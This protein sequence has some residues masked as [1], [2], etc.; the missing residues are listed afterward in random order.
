MG[1]SAMG[2]AP[3]QLFPQG[4]AASAAGIGQNP[5]G[6]ASQTAGGGFNFGAMVPGI[7]QSMQTGNMN[8]L[9]ASAIGQALS[10]G[11]GGQPQKGGF[12]SQHSPMM[13]NRPG[14]FQQPMPSNVRPGMVS[15]IGMAGDPPSA[16]GQPMQRNWGAPSQL[17]THSQGMAPGGGGGAM[18]SGAP[19]APR[20]VGAPPQMVGQP[21][22]G[23]G[24][25]VRPQP[26]PMPRQGGGFAS[27]AV[28][29]IPPP[30]PI[31]QTPAVPPAM[32]NPQPL[33][34]T[35][36]GSNLPPPRPGPGPGPGPAPGAPAAN[37]NAGRIAALQQMLGNPDQSSP[38]AL[39][40]ARNELRSLTGG[41]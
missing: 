37:A 11:F 12:A 39:L 14:V 9:F 35:R 22:L 16:M 41:G 5:T 25:A 38:M 6:I 26:A 18:A 7:M 8:P 31:T 27:P 23:G 21:A 3:R 24:P 40:R 32:R 28:P 17:P 33:F 13:G 19:G 2:G 36:P 20:N 15:G 29:Y 30:P 4:S 1:G 10:G 34:P